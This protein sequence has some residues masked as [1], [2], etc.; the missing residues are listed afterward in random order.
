M[1]QRFT[2]YTSAPPRRIAKGRRKPV[3]LNPGLFITA[4]LMLLAALLLT[5]CAIEEEQP[6]EEAAEEVSVEEVV[7]P[8]P[9]SEDVVRAFVDEGLE[10]GV[11]YDV[12]DDPEW[13]TGMLP[14]T[15][16]SGTRFELPSYTVGQ[17]PSIGGIGDV[18]H[19][20]TSEDQRIVSDYL[21]TVSEASGGTLHTHVYET[22]GFL[23]KIDGNVP[24]NVADRYG[25]VLE[26][27]TG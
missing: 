1:K 8:E 13:G 6:S 16:D 15:M 3:R 2:L 5:G 24:K 14:K 26:E 12:E 17:D 11:Y 7:P 4:L 18:F 25:G 22:D 9:T 27:V 21:E 20:A 23:L 19:F 10:V